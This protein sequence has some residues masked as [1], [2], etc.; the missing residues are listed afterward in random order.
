[1]SDGL[2]YLTSQPGPLATHIARVDSKYYL[3]GTEI[4]AEDGKRLLEEAI[5][6][7]K[8]YTVFYPTRRN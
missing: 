5:N 1:M 4:L 6:K 7:G 3:G 2:G 8:N